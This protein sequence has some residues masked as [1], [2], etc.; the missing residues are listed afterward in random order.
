[1]FF[2]LFKKNST[3][4]TRKPLWARGC[5]PCPPP[6]QQHWGGDFPPRQP[7]RGGE[8]NN[9]QP[10]A[11]SDKGRGTAEQ[12]HI[13]RPVRKSGSHHSAVVGASLQVPRKILQSRSAQKREPRLGTR[14]PPKTDPD[15]YLFPSLFVAA[16]SMNLLLQ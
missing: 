3:S 6:L 16:N 2:R 4:P 10:P 12:K 7:V 5:V 14:A 8:A 15:P 11:R 9:R 13:H 1:M